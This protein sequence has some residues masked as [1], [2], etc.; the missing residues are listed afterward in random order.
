MSTA[1]SDLDS[2][3]RRSQ[4]YAAKRELSTCLFSADTRPPAV[5]RLYEAAGATPVPVMRELDRLRRDGKRSSRIFMCTPVLGGPRRKRRLQLAEIETSKVLMLLFAS[6]RLI[7][8]TGDINEG[9][10]HP[11]KD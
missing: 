3:C 9:D 8:G 6:A 1:E 7:P 4:H 2:F 11:G 5:Q 10:C